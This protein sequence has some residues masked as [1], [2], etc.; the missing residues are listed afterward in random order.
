MVNVSPVSIFS[1]S[2]GDLTV[3]AWKLCAE[4][5]PFDLLAE[6]LIETILRTNLSLPDWSRCAMA[7]SVLRRVVLRLRTGCERVDLHTLDLSNPTVAATS[8]AGLLR[9]L[10]PL[11]RLGNLNTVSLPELHGLTDAALQVV[12]V[13]PSLTHLD[14]RGCKQ[15]TDAGVR[16]LGVRTQSLQSIDL[17][18]CPLVT[19][20]TAAVLRAGCPSLSLVRRQPP[21]LDGSFETPWGETHTY[22]P[23][24]SFA[25]SRAH[26]SRGWISQLVDHRTHV[27]ARLV[28]ANVEMDDDAGDAHNGRIGVLVRGHIDPAG[29][30]C[31]LV[32]QSLDAPEPPICFPNI[33]PDCIPPTG[34]CLRFRGQRGRR[35]PTLLLSSMR[36]TCAGA[37]ATER[38]AAEAEL[39]A[40]LSEFRAH[41][42]LVAREAERRA[43]ESIA[44]RRRAEVRDLVGRT[45]A[46]PAASEPRGAPCDLAAADRTG[47]SG[48]RDSGM[49][50]AS[51]HRDVENALRPLGTGEEVLFDAEGGVLSDEDDSEDGSDM[52][53][54]GV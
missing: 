13:V 11:R 28:Y 46:R 25:F 53:W 8:G 14:L 32:V 6:D 37:A 43:L 10:E 50:H 16:A 48:A 12:G 4:P 51:L 27:E 23:D 17:C 40:E 34:R 36:R 24:G 9:R 52:E 35:G 19:Y 42:S 2:G 3:P 29:G 44:D 45:E 26:E 31:V 54:E 20:A 15:I 33:P 38:D 7:C 18:F 1:L 39:R 22:H 41:F 30:G 49:A 21:W 5:T 47:R